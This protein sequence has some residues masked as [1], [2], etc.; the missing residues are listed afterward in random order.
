MNQLQLHSWNQMV[1]LIKEFEDGK[2]PYHRLVDGLEASLD[3]ADFKDQALVQAWY[4]FWTPLEELDVE[5]SHEI[6]DVSPSQ[7]RPL[8]K[9]LK[10]F[11]VEQLK[12]EGHSVAALLPKQANARH[13][14]R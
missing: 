4:E 12:L 11:L 6:E 9:R 10:D 14:H 2:I 13:A 5:T 8:L 3:D 1:A 7:V